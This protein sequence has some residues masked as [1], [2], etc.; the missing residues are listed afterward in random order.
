MNKIGVVTVTYNSAQVLEEFMQSCLNQKHTN[1]QLYI[2]DSASVDN[3]L[4]LLKQYKDLRINLIPQPRNIGFAKGNNLGIKQALLD[5][6]DYIL[7]LNNDTVFE[8][9]L[10]VTLLHMLKTNNVAMVA[11]KMMY[12]APKDKIWCAGGGFSQLKAMG[13][14]QYGQGKIDKGQYDKDT[15]VDFVPMCCVLFKKACFEQVGDLD[16]K[17][18]VYYEDADWMYRAKQHKLKLLYTAKAVLVHKVSSIT[19]GND[20]DFSMVELA[21]NRTYF[22]RKNFFGYRKYLY[23]SYL[24]VSFIIKFA[25]RGDSLRQFKL[26]LSAFRLGLKL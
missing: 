15:L 13:N 26:K 1:F 10:L 24:L 7:L 8:D 16:E 4:E 22:I 23:L 12:F 20:S 17:F 18:F 11:P 2:I 6:C 14:V 5:G 3:T 19:G 9:S 21:K 25:C